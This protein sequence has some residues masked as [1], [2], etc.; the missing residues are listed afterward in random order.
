MKRGQSLASINSKRLEQFLTGLTN[1]QMDQ[2]AI[3]GFMKRFNDFDLSN[4]RMLALQLFTRADEVYVT[5]MEDLVERLVIPYVRSFFRAVWLEPSPR[6][7]LWAYV[8]FLSDLARKDYPHS[9]G[10]Y[11]SL[12][13]GMFMWLGE[14]SRRASL[15]PAPPPLPIELAFIHLLSYHHRARYCPNSECPAPYFLT[16]RHT[17]KYCSEVCAQNAEKDSKRRWWAQH[18]SA[19]RKEQ[20]QATTERKS[21]K[22][23]SKKPRR[24]K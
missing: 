2:A 4:E 15:P 14:H 8:V 21:S 1:L 7:R 23:I 10:E 17:Q 16:S 12:K 22:K 5:D 18:G 24:G 6:T 11:L 3:R 20:V 9:R 19:R 13:D